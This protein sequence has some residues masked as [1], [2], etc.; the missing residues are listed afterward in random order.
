MKPD[1][2]FFVQD[3]ENLELDETFDYILVNSIND[4]IDVEASF[5]QLRDVSSD[6]TRVLVLGY[7]YLWRPLVGIAEALRLKAPQPV[8]NWFSP[9]DIENL[10]HLAGFE[11]IRTYGHFLLPI[12]IPLLSTLF[13]RVVAR[14]PLF[15]RLTFLYVVVARKVPDWKEVGT[16]TVSV[17]VPCKNE[18][19]NIEPAVTRIPKMGRHTEIIF[20]DDKSTDG[21]ADEVRRMQQKYP[22]K[23]IKLVEGPGIC[24][25]KNVWA[26]FDAAKGEVL[27][28]LDAD[29]TVVPEELPY[30]YKALVEGRG[31]FINGSRLVYPLQDQAMR[32]LIIIGNACFGWAFTFLLGQR[33]KDTL[34]GTKV[35]WRSDYERLKKFRG[36]WGMEDRWGDYE[37]LFGAARLHLKIADLPVHYME[38]VY[39]ETKM[40]NRLSNAWV[41]LRMCWAALFKLKF[42]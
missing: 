18:R 29:L 37:L 33:I 20:S 15:R 36:T 19:G 21:T 12:Y 32:G 39:G 4:I 13:N 26:G 9:K 25:S 42:V 30:F 14:L 11:T 27:M 7:N 40:T 38:R 16:T 22:E 41:M 2:K 17:V 1:L 35:L 24:K 8:P 6:Q 3:P 28:I 10:L 23:D 31:E 5:L 34:C